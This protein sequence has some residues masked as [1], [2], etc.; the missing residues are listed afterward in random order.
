MI[1]AAGKGTRLYPLTDALPK[2]MLPVAGEPV[3][4]HTLRWL[5]RHGIRTVAINLHHQG[6]AI[7][8]AAGDG[9]TF[10]LSILYSEEPELLGTAGGVKRI[11]DFFEDPFVVVYGDV[12]TD[13][14]LGALAGAH[15][16]RQPGGPHATLAV[17]RREDAAQCGV[18]EFDAAGRVQRFVEKPS[19]L[20]RA[21]T[22]WANSGVMV[23][24]RAL[25]AEIPAGRFCD[26]GRDVLP[27][28]LRRGVPLFA[29]PLPATAYLIDMGT[30][31]KYAQANHEWPARAEALRGGRR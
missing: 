5:K 29:W 17:D 11:E 24:D 10:G 4:H 26:F 15:L 1:L 31:E 20:D 3:L 13:L 21:A 18:V 9:R 7:R 28:W 14:D 30:P 23:L 25:L 19:G 8:E 2:P 12:L 16:A 22:P 27:D 6:S